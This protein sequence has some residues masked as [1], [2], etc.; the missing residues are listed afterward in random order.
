MFEYVFRYIN[1]CHCVTVSH[2]M[3]TVT[4]CTRCTLTTMAYMCT[5]LRPLWISPIDCPHQDEIPW[6]CIAQNITLLLVTWLSLRK[7]KF[8]FWN[9]YTSTLKMTWLTCTKLEIWGWK[10]I[11]NHDN[12]IS[13]P[14][15]FLDVALPSSI[16]TC[17]IHIAPNLSLPRAQMTGKQLCI[18]NFSVL[19]HLSYLKQ[20]WLTRSRDK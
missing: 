1:T 10:N 16:L 3:H 17:W 6:G 14:Q 19:N 13:P 12:R 7:T 5:G 18:Y 2:S 8:G 15:P 4:C 20:A 9:T 11:A